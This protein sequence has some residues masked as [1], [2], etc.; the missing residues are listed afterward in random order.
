MYALI[1]RDKAD[2]LDLRM[3]TRAEHLAWAGANAEAI[4]FAGPMVDDDDT[5]L[6]GSIFLLKADSRAEVEAF[7]AD[8]PYT[9]AGLWGS[10]EIQRIRQAIPAPK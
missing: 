3:A 1:C 4:Q 2:G 9:K 5:T 7:H 6:L 8:D 10:V